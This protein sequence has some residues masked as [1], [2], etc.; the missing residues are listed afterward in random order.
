M[1]GGA[2]GEPKPADHAI[3]TERPD[4]DPGFLKTREER[5]VVAGAAN[6]TRMPTDFPLS[7]QPVMEALEEQGKRS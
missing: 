5:V 3:A 6:L 2:D 4:D 7:V 1:G